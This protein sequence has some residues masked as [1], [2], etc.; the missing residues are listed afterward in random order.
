[1][2][3]DK[4]KELKAIIASTLESKVEEKQVRLVKITQ[5]FQ[6]EAI[7]V[8]PKTNVSPIEGLQSAQQFLRG[9]KVVV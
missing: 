6:E 5:D 7:V 4:K 3:E 2:M 9:F 8:R 1:M